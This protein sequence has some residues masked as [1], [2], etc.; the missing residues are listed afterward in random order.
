EG[1]DARPYIGYIHE[2]ALRM[3]FGGRGT[4]KK[5]LEALVSAS[6]RPDVTLRAI[7]F[8][9]GSLPGAD[10]ALLFCEDAVPEL[11]TAQIDTAHGPGFVHTQP[12]LEKYRAHLGWMEKNCLS[13]QS[14]R[15]LMQ[16]LIH[17]L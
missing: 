17:E 12:E 1:P 6:E 16:T 5:Q 11:D 3:Q 13:P 10:H 15:D 2:A 8:E 14:T 9:A 7:P 4:M